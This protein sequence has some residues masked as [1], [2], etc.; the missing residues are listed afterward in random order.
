MVG[1]GFLPYP[2]E[3]LLCEVF[4]I[5]ARGHQPREIGM[6]RIQMALHEF[7]KCQAVA[8]AYQAQEFLI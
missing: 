3:S 1:V 5:A 2:Q 4:G 8:S 7:R 6:Q